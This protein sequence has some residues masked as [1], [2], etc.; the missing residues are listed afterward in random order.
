MQV[1]L[2]PISLTSRYQ[3]RK[4]QSGGGGA[5]ALAQKAGFAGFPEGG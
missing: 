5:V 4:P 3:R 1:L 2:P